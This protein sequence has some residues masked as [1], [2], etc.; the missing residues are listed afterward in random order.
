MGGMMKGSESLI[1]S[2]PAEYRMNP[3]PPTPLSDQVP[4][5]WGSKMHV[6]TLVLMVATVLGFFLCYRMAIP[7]LPGLV[8]AL[9]LAVLFAP[10]QRWLEARIK[11][12]ALAAMVAVLVIALIVVV[13]LTFIGQKL[14]V[15]A[16]KGAELIEF[17]VN[18]GE[19]RRGLQAS[20]A[21]ESMVTQ[22]D[23]RIDL[24]GTVK[25]LTG[26]LISRAG[27]IVKG[28]VF[29]LVDFLLTF[30]LLFFFL[31]D[32]RAALHMIKS[33]SPLQPSDMDRLFHRVGDTIVATIYG[34]LVVA[35]LQGFLGGLMFW[36]LGLPAP[37]MWGT[38]MGVLALVPVLGAFVVWLPAAFFLVM[39]GELGA[40]ACFDAVGAVGGGDD[41]QFVASHFSGEAVEIA[42]GASLHFGAGRAAAVWGGRAYSRAGHS[43][44]DD[45]A[46][47]NLVRSRAGGNVISFPG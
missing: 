45:G 31:R 24:P 16:A 12:H 22:I 38:V 44:G 30:Y 41:R 23:Q 20:P 8:W 26:W 2:I 43:G 4:D 34:T 32:R 9:G 35:A 29:Q 14:V 33:L 37:L 46:A 10:F 21:L 6:Q 1:D 40:G 7:F 18:S 42:H 47:G 25:S 3:S 17:K 39:D 36:W 28:S 5:D 19:W 15:Q 27:S 13:P 11:S